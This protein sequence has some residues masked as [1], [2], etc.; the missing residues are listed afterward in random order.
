M[1]RPYRFFMLKMVRLGQLIARDKS[2]FCIKKPCLK[3]GFFIYEIIPCTFPFNFCPIKGEF[4]DLENMFSFSEKVYVNSGLKRVKF[5]CCPT[6]RG[7][8][9]IPKMDFG[10]VSLSIVVSKGRIQ[11]KAPKADSSPI[12]PSVALSNSNFLCSISNGLWS[13]VI[14]SIV[15][16]LTPLTRA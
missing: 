4:L 16:F 1:P 13:E 8:F 10:K 2:N 9:S 3:Q 14:M 15:P 12:T 6:S 7:W 11:F 5:A